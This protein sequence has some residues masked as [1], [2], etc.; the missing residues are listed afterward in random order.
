MTDPSTREYW[1]P[2]VARCGQFLPVGR[3]YCC[4]PCA[5][6]GAGDYALDAHSFSC[7]ERQTLYRLAQI[8]RADTESRDGR[9]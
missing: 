9:N 7:Q 8:E 2:C 1:A 4:R 3:A 6:A 5:E